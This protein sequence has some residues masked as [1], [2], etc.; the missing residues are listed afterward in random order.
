MASRRIIGSEPRKPAPT[1]AGGV[2]HPFWLQQ[3]DAPRDMGDANARKLIW[4]LVPSWDAAAGGVMSIC[5]V[6][7]E[8]R[9]LLG[10]PDVA[11]VASTYPDHPTLKKYTG[12]ANSMD[13]FSFS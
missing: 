10:G 7:A 12:F 1:T 8:T 4:F 11:V 3:A 2:T 6:H 5:S 9:M 13:I